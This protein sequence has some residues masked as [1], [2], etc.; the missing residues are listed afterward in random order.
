MVTQIFRVTITDKKK[1]DPANIIGCIEDMSETKDELVVRVRE[2][3]PDTKNPAFEEGYN[4]LM[5]H[6]DN[7]PEEEKAQADKELKRMGC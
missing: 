1:T 6:F 5:E 2:I 4:I 7:I 3:K